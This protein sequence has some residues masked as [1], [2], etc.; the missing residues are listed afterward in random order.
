LPDLET[1]LHGAIRAW[2][3]DDD[4]PAA[5]T[6]WRSSAPRATI[7]AMSKTAKKRLHEL[8]EALPESE[9]Y[10]ARRYLEYLRDQSDPYARLDDADPF[11]Q[12]PDEERARL[13]AALDQAEKEIAAGK[14]IPAEELLLELRGR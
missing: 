7:R 14:G 10:A 6:P 2:D 5:R 8:V 9:T 4:G 11:E 3:F 1:R 12:M 13:H